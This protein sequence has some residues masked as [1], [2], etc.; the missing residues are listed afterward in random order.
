MI[1][2]LSLLLW[3]WHYNII[4]PH[5][6]IVIVRSLIHHK[7]MLVLALIFLFTTCHENVTLRAVNSR[8]MPILSCA[9]FTHLPY[10]HLTY[11]YICSDKIYYAIYEKNLHFGKI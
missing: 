1:T 6:R 7:A 8:A 3:L 11:R 5:T 9:C 4:Y 2:L 10:T